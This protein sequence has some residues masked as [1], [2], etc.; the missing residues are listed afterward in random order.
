MNMKINIVDHKLLKFFIGI[1]SLL[2]TFLFSSG[3]TYAQYDGGI[4]GGEVLGEEVKRGIP[5]PYLIG[6]LIVFIL[7]GILFFLFKKYFSK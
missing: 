7:G 6:T 3:T 5:T 4:G 1:F 2:G